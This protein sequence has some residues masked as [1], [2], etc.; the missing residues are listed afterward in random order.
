MK[1]TIYYYLTQMPWFRM[2]VAEEPLAL[3]TFEQWY[4]FGWNMAMMSSPS[5]GTAILNVILIP[6]ALIV[7][8][9]IYGLLAYLFA[10]WLG[11]TAD[12]SQTLGVLALAV[13][14]Q[15]L[16][17]LTVFPY[18]QP[19]NI[20]AVWGILCAYV[21]LKKAHGLTWDRAVWATLLPFILAI[22]LIILVSCLATAAF[23]VMVGGAS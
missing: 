18:V 16:N 21:G 13:A 6:V 11:G 9:L 23:A 22:A 5:V 10:R 12:L 14:P 20:I 3:Q 1:D 19:G 7:R 8:W 2:M 4:D 15:A 17:A